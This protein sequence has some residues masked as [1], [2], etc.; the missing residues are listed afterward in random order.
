M[1]NTTAVNNRIK[2]IK[3][4]SWVGIIGNGILAVLKV[5]VGL[6]SGSVAVIADGIDSA[7]D[8]VG[9]IITYYASNV[10]ER[11]PDKE[12]PWGHKRIEAIAT[13]VI[14]I[15]IL[16]AGLQLVIST[17]SMLWKG[18]VREIPGYAAI[19]VTIIS[20][21]GKAGIAIYKF[22]VAG[23]TNSLMVKADAINMK[24]D[25]FLSL[26]V[27]VGLG[28]TYITN[29]PIIDTLV[30]VALGLW[31]IKS[32]AELSIESNTELMDSFE[33]QELWYKKLFSIAE[34]TDGVYNPHR[35]R[36]RKLNNLYD[37]HLDI[38]VD[39]HLSIKQGHVIVQTLEEN[40]KESFVDV[41]DIMIHIE[42]LGN[43]ED[44]EFGLRPEDFLEDKV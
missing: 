39:A 8:I 40:I 21:I 24:N 28:L 32:G 36:I 2:L 18:E 4:S 27:L 41:F 11:P 22:R 20:I 33:N 14:A 44:E 5:V 35:A 16:F 34:E 25:I 23:K 30:G 38:E 9:S 15:L 43:E 31:I 3:Q 29:L 26:S 17:V 42:P 12:H 1:S 10:S 37:I 13:K 6:I 19:V 7:S